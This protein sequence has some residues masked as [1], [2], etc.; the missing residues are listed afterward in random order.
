MDNVI[1]MT[2]RPS[3]PADMSEDVCENCQ[4]SKFAETGPHGECRAFPPICGVILVPRQNALGQ[5]EPS[6]Q[7]WSAWPTV[8]RRAFCHTFEPIDGAIDPAAHH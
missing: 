3:V 2:P 1:D 8:E 4:F 7:P 6:I 5:M